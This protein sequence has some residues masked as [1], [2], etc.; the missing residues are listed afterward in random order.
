M[1]YNSIWSLGE[2]STYSFYY[3]FLYLYHLQQVKIV[4]LVSYMCCEAVIF[5]KERQYDRIDSIIEHYSRPVFQFSLQIP[6]IFKMYPFVKIWFI[7]GLSLINTEFYSFSF[8]LN[9]LNL[10]LLF[11]YCQRQFILILS[12]NSD[13]QHPVGSF[14]VIT[15]PQL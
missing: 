8:T 3:G 4:D 6:S 13:I 2:I 9:T 10:L 12:N 1:K 15:K 11:L 14:C 7:I 5:M